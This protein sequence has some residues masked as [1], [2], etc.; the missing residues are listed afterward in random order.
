MKKIIFSTIVFLFICQMFSQIKK[1][2]ATLIFKDG[3]E[4]S[5]FAR[6]SGKNVRYVESDSRSSEIVV[7]E[8]DILGLKIYLNDKLLEFY[9]KKEEGKDKFKLMELV[10]NGKIKL[11]RIQDVYSENI[12]MNSN[13][14][15]MNQKFA[16]SKF[17]L[18]SK[19]NPDEVIRLKQDFEEDAK[20]Y[21]A[22]CKDLVNKLGQDNFRKKDILTI[23]V[24]Y[25]ENCGE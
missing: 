11:Y 3:K 6:I 5:C 9:Y 15:Y 4:L 18:I 14:S 12:S 23:V 25:N 10:A 16:S 7:D 2:K 1:Q 8:K 19:T 20:N 21:F 24:F 22:D 13:R 17:F